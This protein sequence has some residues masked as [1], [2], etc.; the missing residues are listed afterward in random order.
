[1]KSKIVVCHSPL[2]I[3]FLF[4]FAMGQQKE[5][6]GYF[7]SW[8]W[9]HKNALMTYD[10]IPFKKV[11]IIDYAFWHPLLDGTIAGINPRGDSLILTGGKGETSLV[12]LAHKNNVKVMLSIGGWED[13]ENFPAVASTQELRTTFAHACLDAIRKFDFDGIDIDWEYPGYA[14]HKGTAADRTNSTAFLA[15]LRDS[16]D[17]YG[18]QAHKKLFLSAALAAT[19]EHLSGYEVEKLIPVLDMFNVMTYDYNGSWS[20]RSGYNSP[21][22]APTEADSLSNIDATFKLFTG[23]FHVPAAKINLGVPF[24]GHVFA[25]CTMP[26]GDYHG[27]D[28]TLFPEEDANYYAIVQYTGAYRH[29]D[30]KAK[31]PYLVVPSTKTFVSYDD[32]ESVKYKARYVID[33][34]ARGVIIWEITADYMPDGKTPLLDVLYTTFSSN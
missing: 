17:S 2:L 8:N 27:V 26:G 10:K 23:V 22:Y 14:E 5:V 20:V 9:Q 15:T 6:V 11:T 30:D 34:H 25:Q 7:P 1:M 21:L 12:S 32:E 31:V 19:A 28:T 18:L 24:Y 3:A 16:L 33:Q 13:S 29:W 4:T